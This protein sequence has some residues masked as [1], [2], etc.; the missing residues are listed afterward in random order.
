MAHLSRV[1]RNELYKY[2]KRKTLSLHGWRG[3][4]TPQSYIHGAQTGD[5][6][7][8]Q[9]GYSSS[10]SPGS[11]YDARAFYQWPSQ[12]YQPAESWFDGAQPTTPPLRQELPHAEFHETIRYQ[13]SLMTSE[14]LESATKE[15][16]EASPPPEH[17]WERGETQ[18]DAELEMSGLPDSFGPDDSATDFPPMTESLAELAAEM[19][20]PEALVEDPVEI[21]EG[22]EL[23]SPSMLDELQADPMEMVPDQSA[24]GGLDALVEQAMSE[25]DPF[26]LQRR[27]YDEQMAVMDPF[28][29]PGPFGP[30][31]TPMM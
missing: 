6:L 26:E 31:P 24:A 21:A 2:A 3:G 8:P 9:T 1:L 15:V 20:P 10:T 29:M 28:M 19:V 13:D 11:F 25:E 5:L 27:M 17:L 16:I 23:A 22:A 4:L 14:L 7:R 30:G 12:N 18:E